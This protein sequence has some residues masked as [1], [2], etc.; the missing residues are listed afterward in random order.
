MRF[1]GVPGSA[2][3]QALMASAAPAAHAARRLM[4]TTPLL[5]SWVE[6]ACGSLCDIFGVATETGLVVLDTGATETVGS[7]EAVQMLVTNVQ[8]AMPAAQVVVDVE[9]GQQMSFKLADGAIACAYSLVW[10]ETPHGWLSSYVI[11]SSGVPMLLS[12]KGMRALRAVIDLY[13]SVISY[14]ATD[15]TGTAFTVERRLD[16][17][18]KGHLLWDPS[19]ALTGR[20]S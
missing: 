16:T 14:R 18:P 20:G 9:A 19:D 6:T 15:T 4:G 17:S 12:I 2:I 13:T 5:T 11:E 1:Q 10:V 3:I 7:P 8:R